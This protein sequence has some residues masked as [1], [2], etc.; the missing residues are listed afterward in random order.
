MT[1]VIDASV[2]LAW[3][4]ED[5]RTDAIAAVMYAV[6]E[7]GA[8][9]PPMWRYEVANGLQV[10]IRR[11]RIDAAYRDASLADLRRMSFEHDP[12]CGAMTWS[13]T[14]LLADRYRLTVYD[15]A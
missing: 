5:E 15:A 6:N 14:L 11:H 7:A 12:D 13:A 3:F 1:F 8:V 4:F 10:A 9:V 2:T